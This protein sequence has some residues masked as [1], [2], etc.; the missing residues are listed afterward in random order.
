MGRIQTVGV[1]PRGG[2]RDVGVRVQMADEE[3]TPWY[4]RTI[5]I[6]EHEI[7]I[8]KILVLIAIGGGAVGIWYFY[9]R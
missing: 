1:L 5:E 8:W 4:M 3:E 6:G 2:S 7:E 9:F